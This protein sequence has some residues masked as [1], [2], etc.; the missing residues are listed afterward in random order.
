MTVALIA[1]P[2]HVAVPGR[3]AGA[4]GAGRV[5]VAVPGSVRGA[6]ALVAAAFVAWTDGALAF[7]VPAEHPAAAVRTAPATIA[8]DAA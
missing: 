7:A 2:V 3:A 5:S 4:A 6:G 8:K 1:L